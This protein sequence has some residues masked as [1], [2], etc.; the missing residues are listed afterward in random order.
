MTLIKSV[1]K[2]P[3]SKPLSVYVDTFGTCKVD[4][5]KLSKIIQEVMDLSPRGIRE[6]LGLN[7]PI[8]TPTSSYG[9]FGRN[10]RKDGCFSWEKL[11]IIDAHNHLHDE[12]DYVENLLRTMDKYNISIL[13]FNLNILFT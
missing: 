12:P 3:V 11:D 9:H 5:V 7:K 1:D 6:H 4:E 8:Y 10:P 2:F 13:D